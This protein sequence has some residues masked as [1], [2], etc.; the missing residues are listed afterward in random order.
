MSVRAT[1]DVSQRLVIS[2]FSGEL[3]DAD[4][5]SIYSLVRSLPGFDPS[6]SEI[7]DF[8]GITVAA[9]STTAIQEASQRPSNFHPTSIHVIIAPQDHL[10]GL[11]RMSQVFAEKTRPNAVV[12]RTLDEAREFLAREKSALD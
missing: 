1:I 6:F 10:F 8:S 9:V 7:L 12:V 11:A 2:T 4:I 5:L 3:T